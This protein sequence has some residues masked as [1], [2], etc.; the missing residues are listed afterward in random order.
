MAK[1]NQHPTGEIIIYQPKDGKSSIEVKL[2]EE[3]VWL[4]QKQMA[5][6]FG[7]SRVTITEHIANVFKEGELDK[8]LVCRDF[9]HTAKD[10]KSYITRYY[11]LDVIISVGYR[12]KSKQGTQFRI[13]AT[14]TLREHLIKGFTLNE[15]RLKSNLDLKLRELE[16]AISLMQNTMSKKLLSQDE[17]TGLLKIITDYTNSWVLLQK[18]DKEEI[19]EPKHKQ[20]AKYELTYDVAKIT[21]EKLKSELINKKEATKLFGQERD[22]SLEGII[23][24]LYQTF[25]GKDLYPSIEDKASH[26]LYFVIK[27]HP[28]VD[29]NKRIG[30]FL[31]I[32]FL[33]RNNYLFKKNGERKF[34]DNALVALALLT[35]KSNPKQKDTL[36]KLIMNF[37]SS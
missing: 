24:N 36:I 20:E 6:L 23:G 31:F 18:Y 8:K 5:E 33:A 19:K 7:K 28:F 2:E 1:I 34:N 13:W 37:I 25:G 9:R 16:Q 30:S 4:N 12:V 35:A 32:L 22:R 11:N 10:G 27:D 29:G 15:K 26:L 17:A 21:I 3:T 14:R